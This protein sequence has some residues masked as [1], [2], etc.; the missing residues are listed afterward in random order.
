MVHERQD[1]VQGMQGD[2]RL[3][4]PGARGTRPGAAPESPMQ[5]FG[6]RADKAAPLA[7][8]VGGE[9]INKSIYL[10]LQRRAGPRI[11][12]ETAQTLAACR[13]RQPQRGSSGRIVG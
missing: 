3:C 1:C 13:S 5:A 6:T 7:S 2:K 11:P 4:G 12:L 10:L 9:R 8:Y